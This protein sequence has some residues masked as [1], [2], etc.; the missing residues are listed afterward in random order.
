[1]LKL[2]VFF[3]S[4]IF[5]VLGVSVIYFGAGG[6]LGILL[7][8]VLIAEGMW[9]LMKL[10]GATM[11]ASF[12]IFFIGIVVSTAAM[13]SF[14]AAIRYQ[15]MY[16][17]LVFF[18]LGII[19]WVTAVN[20]WDMREPYKYEDRVIGGERFYVCSNNENHRV[21]WRDGCTIAKGSDDCWDGCTHW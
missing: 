11:K 12:I 3:S 9:N 2:L 7:G 6:A 19:G 21:H 15:Q 16:L 13:A 4:I 14:F 18:V 17:F 5:I 10:M 20:G 8:I 1:M